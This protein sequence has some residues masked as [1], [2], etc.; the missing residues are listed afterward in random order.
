[1]ASNRVRFRAH[2]M[3]LKGLLAVLSLNTKERKNSALFAFSRAFATLG[4]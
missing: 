4:E 1:M 3:R 2:Q